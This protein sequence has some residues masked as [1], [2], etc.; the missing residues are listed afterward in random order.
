MN[1]DVE[2]VWTGRSFL[3][4]GAN[5]VFEVPL[6]GPV[7]RLAEFPDA[8]TQVWQV[9]DLGLILISS[10]DRFFLYDGA[11]VVYSSGDI[12]PASSIEAALQGLKPVA[13]DPGVGRVS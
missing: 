10:C 8:W 12:P 13:Y 1:A 5:G 3:S 7:R 11:E 9:P 2:P 6:D 4:G